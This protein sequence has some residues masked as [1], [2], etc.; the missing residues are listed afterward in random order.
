MKFILCEEC[1][2]E[3]AEKCVVKQ[4]IKGVVL[5]PDSGCTEGVEKEDCD[6]D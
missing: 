6:R 1:A 4:A 3:N 2:Y 5:T